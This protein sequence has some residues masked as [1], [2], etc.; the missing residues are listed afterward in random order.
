MIAHVPV[1]FLLPGILFLAVGYYYLRQSSGSVAGTVQ[2]R[3][4]KLA[5]RQA[6]IATLGFGVMLLA[7]AVPLIIAVMSLD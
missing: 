4:L 2:D 1:V 3:R 5:R 6:G 7:I